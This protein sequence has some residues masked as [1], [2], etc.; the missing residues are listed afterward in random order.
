MVNK[1][2]IIALL[3]LFF[4]FKAQVT[5]LGPPTVVNKV[6]ELEDGSKYTIFKII[7]KNIQELDIP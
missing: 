2:T 6:K 4:L 5:I 7:F 3:S 1:I